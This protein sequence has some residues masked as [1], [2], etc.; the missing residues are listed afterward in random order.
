MSKDSSAYSVL[1]DIPTLYK[2]Y[3]AEFLGAMAIVCADIHGK[4]EPV[5]DQP[6]IVVRV[7]NNQELMMHSLE[8]LKSYLINKLVSITGSVLRVSSI[9][10]LVL[11]VDFVCLDC[12]HR[13]HVAFNNGKYEGPS[14]CTGPSCRSKN[15][16][17]DKSSAQTS[18][19]QRVRV[20][21]IDTD[22]KAVNAGKMPKTVECELRDDLVDS[23]VSGDVIELSGVLKPE[24]STDD[25]RT[26]GL[27]SSYIDVNSLTHKNCIYNSCPSASVAMPMA[28]EAFLHEQELA[29][30]KRL[31]DIASRP[32][33]VPL[34]V[35]SMCPQI[36]GQEMVK[37]GLL[38][39][40]FGGADIC[41]G[42]EARERTVRPDVHVLIVGDPGVGKSQLLKY[43]VKVSPRGFYI[44]GKSTTNAGLT[45]AVCKD[46]IANE[47]TLEAGALVLSDLGICCI[48]EFDKMSGDYSVRL[49]LRILDRHC[50]R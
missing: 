4:L 18:F 3:P 5:Q 13:V 20:Q 42:P 8:D 28:A 12:K 45:V 1:S 37:F 15:V 9:N 33:V 31:Q 49:Q 16:V 44:C 38:L 41:P 34:L 21:E 46:P 19:F 32:D 23:C 29:E 7:Y 2:E 43:L 25:G 40:L 30:Q 17:A 35:K 22:L 14:M 26:K 36:Y 47:Q 48:D 6:R 27:F 10:V 39:S 24:L 11:S 50:W